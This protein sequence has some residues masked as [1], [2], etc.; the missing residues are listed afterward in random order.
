MFRAVKGFTKHPSEALHSWQST[1]R[2][3]NQWKK[4]NIATHWK[5]LCQAQEAAAILTLCQ[6]TQFK[7]SNLV[8]TQSCSLTIHFC[9]AC[10]IEWN[11]SISKTQ[12]LCHLFHSWILVVGTNRCSERSWKRPN[13][14]NSSI[15][16][17]SLTSFTGLKV[18]PEG[19]FPSVK[20]WWGLKHVKPQLMEGHIT[21]KKINWR[22]LEKIWK[23]TW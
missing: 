5:I 8:L 4:L 3:C 11:S 16:M 13:L 7:G 22:K 12:Y 21:S 15:N 23:R 9:I 19:M 14:K 18:M 2:I 10:T 17:S 1:N 6:C 20:S